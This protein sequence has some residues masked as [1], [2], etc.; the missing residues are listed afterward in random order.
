[1]KTR[2]T[3]YPLPSQ[4]SSQFLPLALPSPRSIATR[5]SSVQFSHIPIQAL[6]QA[7]EQPLALALL[8]QHGAVLADPVPLDEALL[9]FLVVDLGLGHAAESDQARVL[10]PFLVRVAP[11]RLGFEIVGRAANSQ[12][13][14]TRQM[15]FVVTGLIRDLFQRRGVRILVLVDRARSEAFGQAFTFGGLVGFFLDPAEQP[16]MF[17]EKC[18][19][20][21]RFRQDGPVGEA[22]STAFE[23][24]DNSVAHVGDENSHSRHGDERPDDEEG[25]PSI[26]GGA[27]VT[28]T[29]GK[30]RD[31]AEV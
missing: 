30:E 2:D 21:T 18:A 31:V 6:A 23:R 12:R 1:M 17:F 11:V 26:A 16:R 5:R 10:D 13:Q 29:D 4:D 3:K 25:F 24:R 8:G 15:M 20:N 22:E 19:P 7:I 14:F 27:K 28:V 9:L